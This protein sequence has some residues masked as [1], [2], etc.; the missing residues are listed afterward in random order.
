MAPSAAIANV[1]KQRRVGSGSSERRS[2]HRILR[3]TSGSRGDVALKLSVQNTSGARTSNG[4]KALDNVSPAGS[5]S[6][7]DRT[8]SEEI[9]RST[10]VRK[11]SPSS[12][13]AQN[14]LQQTTPHP[15]SS[16]EGTPSGLSSEDSLPGEQPSVPNRSRLSL[17][18]VSNSTANRTTSQNGNNIAGNNMQSSSEKENELKLAHNRIKLELLEALR[19]KKAYSSALL[20]IKEQKD[21]LEKE[22]GMLRQ[23]NMALETAMNSNRR[24]KN[25]KKPVWSMDNLRDSNIASYQG[26]CL[27]AGELTKTEGTLLTTETYIDERN[28]GLRKRNWTGS[29]IAVRPEAAKESAVYVILP[30][31]SYSIPSCCMY[32]AKHGEHSISPYMNDK[33]FAKFC[34]KKTLS[35]PVGSIMTSSEKAECETLILSHPQ[36]IRKFKS[37]LSDN[38]GNRKKATLGIFLRSL[39]YI[40]GARPSSKKLTSSQE[41]VRKTERQIAYDKCVKMNDDGEMDTMHWR[42]NS[43]SS[44]CLNAADISAVSREMKEAE[45]QMESEGVV[46]NWFLNEAARRSFNELRGHQ[47]SKDLDAIHTE[48]SIL[49]LARADAGITTMLKWLTVAGRGGVRNSNYN[50]CF[51][52]LL[53]KAMEAIL[54]EVWDDLEALVPNEFAPYIGGNNVSGSDRY[55]NEFREWT[56]VFN[57]P[58]DNYLYLLAKPIYFEKKVCSWIGHVKDCTIGRCRPGETLF[59]RITCATMYKEIEESDVDDS[60]REELE[61]ENESGD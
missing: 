42:L 50:D 54:R 23:Q 7:S 1:N 59:T 30:D 38:V 18:R 15:P 44:L 12:A 24:S 13:N 35:S 28:N 45:K 43:W 3:S 46:D 31:G 16:P 60:P 8:I 47:V 57:N 14:V 26:I 29:C 33:G 17:R 19:D 48:V 22:V 5:E 61:G 52:E 51:R 9:D 25:G 56:C 32:R 36:T 49:S 39:G 11:P 10:E 4:T 34:I 55:G 53:P 40:N 58:E 2:H 37:I 20:S 27:A 21:S 41:N 6:Q